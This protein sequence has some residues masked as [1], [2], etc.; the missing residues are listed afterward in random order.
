MR[1]NDLKQLE[2]EFQHEVNLTQITLDNKMDWELWIESASSFKELKQ[3][4]TKRG[5][6][7]MPMNDKPELL[8]KK[9]VAM[10][11]LKKLPN[12]KIMMK[13]GSQSA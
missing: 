3:H 10:G 4:L 2:L 7:G 11:A 6:K 5:Y 13:R 12:Q 1:L 9:Q 8:D